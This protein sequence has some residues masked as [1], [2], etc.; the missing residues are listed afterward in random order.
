MSE[1]PKT[2]AE[3]ALLL[4]GPYL[5]LSFLFTLVT[6]LILLGNVAAVA[7]LTDRQTS[8]SR[9]INVSGRQRMLSQRITKTSVQLVRGKELT[10]ARIEALE[11]ELSRSID[12]WVSADRFLRDRPG[13]RIVNSAEALSLFARMEPHF[14]QVVRSA[15][16][17][18]ETLPTERPAQEVLLSSIELH[19]AKF[20]PL[21]DDLVALYAKEA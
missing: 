21:M 2:V 5:R 14:D 8:D 1:T 17:V 3:G 6:T 18:L 4:A 12:E 11:E 13:D 10:P 9:V 15:R 16:A 20:L 19:E 7:D